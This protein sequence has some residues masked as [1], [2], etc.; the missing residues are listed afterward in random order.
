M[1]SPLHLLVATDLSAA[2]PAAERGALLAAGCGARLTLLHVLETPQAAA[3]AE[4]A[5]QAL[6]AG[7][8]QRHGVA[9]MT[10]LEQGEVLDTL[11]RQADALAA[12]ML[13]L[14][15]PGNGV[16][17]DLLLGHT[18]GHLLERLRCPLLIVRQPAVTPYQS[19]LLPV[20]FS[21]CSPRAASLA[22][23]LLPQVPLTLLHAFELPFETRLRRTGVES[24]ALELMLDE[25]RQQAA[26]Q[27]Q[28]LR[29]DCGLGGAKHHGLIR[30]GG[31]VVQVL[32]QL[33]VG[34]HDLLLLCRQPQASLLQLLRGRVSQPLLESANIDTLLA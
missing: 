18:A 20:D 13:V 26:Q 23:H 3:Q 1:R 25:A 27:M 34:R 8:Q 11:C 5:L 30:H 21:A 32:D 7:L 24:S 15:A 6:A 17:H 9:A 12:D 19:P 10:R 16:L 4:A 31:A 14:G 2:S 22:Q 29:D 33:R 28:Q